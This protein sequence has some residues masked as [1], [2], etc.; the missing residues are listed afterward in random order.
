MGFQAN[1]MA[2][3][4]RGGRDS[5]AE[6]KVVE[7]LFVTWFLVESVIRCLGHPNY[8]WRDRLLLFD[9]GIVAASAFEIWILVP[10]G[11]VG[12]AG[13]TVSIFVVLRVLRLARAVKLLR[14]VEAFQPLYTMLQAVW[15]SKANFFCV[16][17][18]LSLYLFGTSLIVQSL[19]GPYSGLAYDMLEDDMIRHRFSSIGHCMLTLVEI[20]FEGD[21]WGPNVVEK[22]LNGSTQEATV[23]GV[24]LLVF[25][26]LGQFFVMNLVAALFIEQMFSTVRVNK[27]VMERESM[28]ANQHDSEEMRKIFEDIA[29]GRTALPWR[30]FAKGLSA[31]PDLVMQLG[32][33][34]EVAKAL[35]HQLSYDVSETVSIEEFIFGMI[36]LTRQSKSIDMLVIDYQ[37]QRAQRCVAKLNK[38]FTED[39][40]RLRMSTKQ[41]GK[42][43]AGIM[44]D[45]APLRSFLKRRLTKQLR[46]DNRSGDPGAPQLTTTTDGAAATASGLGDAAPTST[47]DGPRVKVGPDP[48]AWEAWMQLLNR[49]GRPEMRKRLTAALQGH[50]SAGSRAIPSGVTPGGEP[51]LSGTTGTQ[52]SFGVG[53][54]KTAGSV[55]R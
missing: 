51:L 43:L 21:E 41:L 28:Y 40:A 37:Q 42:R 29:Q 23:S 47:P 13:M 15:Y 12:D 16:C 49:E 53:A 4:A 32:I 36:K 38:R 11:A 46:W 3:K 45:C 18:V 55:G 50:G 34:L 52:V 44:S 27:T 31:N 54:S 2:E 1:A 6:Y 33:N 20:L 17:L 9:I 7:S 5:L 10:T 30:E 26:L 25:A 22:L 8:F 24:V 19:I 35:F 14:S 39:A 48:P